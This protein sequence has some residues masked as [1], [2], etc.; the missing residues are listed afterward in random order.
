MYK[1]TADKLA[2]KLDLICGTEDNGFQD[3]L[4][5]DSK[6]D[7]DLLI[8]QLKIKALADMMSRHR[9]MKDKS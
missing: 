4:K 5:R 1:I 9:S 7:V 8:E 6:D 2:E 3:M